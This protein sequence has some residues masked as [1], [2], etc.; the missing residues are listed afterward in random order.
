[1]RPPATE[2]PN[3]PPSR[4]LGDQIDPGRAQPAD[5][6]ILELMAD[7]E[8]PQR[9]AAEVRAL[10]LGRTG[11]LELQRAFAGMA[12]AG[13]AEIG[14]G[15]RG[16]ALGDEGGVDQRVDPLGHGG[17]VVEIQHQNGTSD[18]GGDLGHL[19]AERLD[20]DHDQPVHVV[21]GQLAQRPVPADPLHL[22]A[23]ARASRRAA[24]AFPLR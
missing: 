9:L 15:R 10:I 11:E 5:R 12:Q 18:L 19:G 17:A 22:G 23:R 3:W 16:L 21:L 2:K 14:P 8:D 1:M 6:Q 24:P 20:G 13:R 7:G 4:F